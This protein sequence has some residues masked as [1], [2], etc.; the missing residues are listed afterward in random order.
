MMLRQPSRSLPGTVLSPT[1]SVLKDE[2]ERIPYFLFRTEE[3]FF[4]EFIFG[5]DHH[6]RIEAY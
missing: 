2:S 1:G 3:D 4:M 6:D 5:G